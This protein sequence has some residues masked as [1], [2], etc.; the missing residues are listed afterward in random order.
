MPD[1]A[2]SCGTAWVPM[3]T[4]SPTGVYTIEI[5]GT[6]LSGNT[7]AVSTSSVGVVTAVDFSGAEPML[8]VGRNKV[9]LKDITDVRVV[10]PKTETA[11]E[12]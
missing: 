10:E 3:A 8:T 7:I 9:A 11:A 6:N 5:K 12:S 4:S 1:P 2:S